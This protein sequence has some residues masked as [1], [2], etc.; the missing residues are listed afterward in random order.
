METSLIFINLS[1]FT[2]N[3]IL[4]LN[5]QKV[6]TY[7][8]HGEENLTKTK[9]FKGFNILF[10]ITHLM[11]LIFSDYAQTI[12][13][14]GYSLIT[15]YLAFIAYEGASWFNRVKF[16]SKKKEPKDKPDNNE[17]SVYDDNYNTKINN[18]FIFLSIFA[19]TLVTILNQWNMESALEQKG[20]LGIIL[21]A[22]VF[23]SNLWFPNIFK[24]LSL[25][26]SNRVGKDDVVRINK[27]IFIVY[28]MSLQYTTL[29]DVMSNKRVILENS[30]FS[31]NQI[32]NLSKRAS[33]E[34]Y[35]DYIDFKIAYPSQDITTELEY[36]KHI[37]KWKKIFEETYA[38]LDDNKSLKIRPMYDLKLIEPGDFALTWRFSFYYEEFGKMNSTGAI[39]RVL[40]SKYELLEII[41]KKAHIKG[42]SLSTPVLEMNP[43][44]S[45]DNSDLPT[46]TDNTLEDETMVS[47]EKI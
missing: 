6:V 3:L 17:P 8:N 14:V 18:I 23:T 20:V 31:S 34:G 28:D 5:A 33:S 9:M 44:S 22:L 16:G 1:L 43:N 29:H 12:I 10:L 42:I 13:H 40:A 27:K 35:R 37:N 38:K 39:R 21:A 30:I 47:K 2:L 32:A 11:D 41:Q 7:L 25:M 15:F 46:N 26:N 45:F 19:I 4:F 24:G 36:D